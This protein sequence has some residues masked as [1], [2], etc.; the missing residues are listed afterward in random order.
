MT[1]G[2][3]S[4][5]DT[6][7][8]DVENLDGSDSGDTLSGSAAANA[9]AGGGGTDT[10]NGLGGNDTLDP[11]AGAGDVTDGGTGID[12]AYKRPSV[13]P[14]LGYCPPV[15]VTVSLDGVANDGPAGEADNVKTT[16]ENLYGSPVDDTLTGSN[17]TANVLMGY[18]GNDVLDGLGGNDTIV[19]G[20]GADQLTGNGGNDDID[21]VDG[22]ADTLISCG[23]GTDSA[24]FDSG[25]ETTTGCE[26]TDPV[27]AAAARRWRPAP[28][29]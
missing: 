10:L 5:G 14:C 22:A 7:A 25:L 12:G 28:S 17:T 27:S 24:A 26:A 21:A 15:G 16:V 9:I 29:V 3:Q 1:A 6:I 19:G 13:T 11:G 2:S 18:G 23:A 4:E 8:R 20:A